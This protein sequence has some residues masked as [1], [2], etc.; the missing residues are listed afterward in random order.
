MNIKV[1]RLFVAAAVVTAASLFTSTVS[2]QDDASREE[3]RER[4]I[5]GY[6]ERLEVKAEA[7]WKEKIRPLVVKVVDAQREARAGGFGGFGRG[8]QGGGGGG[9][10]DQGSRRGFG[11]SNPDYDALRKAI[12]DKAPAEE[13]KEKLAKYRESRKTK[14]AA[15]EKAQEELRKALSPRQEAAAV[16]V[17]LLK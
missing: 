2:A 1:Q 3:R 6:K 8:G 17:G 4:M 9:G 15:L 5:E 13:V 16:M 11:Q 14:E 10:G 12:E 7:D